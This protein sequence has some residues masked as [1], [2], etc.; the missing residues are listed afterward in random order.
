MDLEHNVNFEVDKDYNTNAVRLYY[1]LHEYL[2]Q[3]NV[4]NCG[5]PYSQFIKS[6]CCFPFDLTPGKN[7]H[8]SDATSL[9]RRGEL[10]VKLF[11]NKPLEENIVLL[12][13]SEFHST[14]EVNADCQIYLNYN[15]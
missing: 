10:S 1:K 3:N 14:F 8:Q 7:A 6:L 13:Y 11:F 12:M 9:V 15:Q 2:G 5:I 4:H